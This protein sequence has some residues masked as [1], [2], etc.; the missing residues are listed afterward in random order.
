MLETAGQRESLDQGAAGSASGRTAPTKFRSGRRAT[1]R[2]TPVPAPRDV[3]DASRAKPEPTPALDPAADHVANWGIPLAVVVIG[4]FM[5]VLDVSIVNVAIPAMQKTYGA[6]TDDIEWVATAYNLCLGVVVPASAW[7]GERFGLRRIYIVS[8][9]GF[10]VF[11]GFCGTA[12][13]LGIMIFYRVLQAVPGGLLPV[14]C[15]AILTRIVPPK[16]LGTAMGLYGLGMVVAPGIGPALGGYLVQHLDWRLIFFINVPIGVAGALAAQLVLPRLPGRSSSTFDLPGFACAATGLFAIL[17]AVSEGHQWGWTSYPVLILLAVAA[18]LIVVFVIIERQ[19]PE[20]LLDVRV[21]LRWPFTI[22][23]VLVSLL[24]IGLFAALYY[25]PLFL[26]NGQDITPMNTGLTVLP[27]AA[28]MMLIMPVAGR[29]YDRFGA[30]WPAAIGVLLAGLGLGMMSGFNPDMT[31]GQIVAW[32]VVQASGLA[33]AFIPIM[34]A[35][36]A[37]LPTHLVDSGNAYTNLAQR[38][39]GALGIAIFTAITA[40]WQAQDMADRS[41]LLGH[42]AATN[43]AIQNLRQQ[44]PGGLVPLW[45]ETFVAAQA[46]SYSNAFLC[47]SAVTIL[48]AFLAMLFSHGKPAAGTHV[49]VEIG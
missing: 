6:S 36:L 14:T 11:S 20:P 39:A 48:S 33:I 29:I 16:Q 35:G 45:R 32:T 19:V 27:Q 49:H 30:R 23:I 15:L 18:N 31:R 4:M 3:A 34:T 12:D 1:T 44:G 13:S 25:V 5:S 26:Q 43:P 47:L 9:L 17:L 10:A 22:S 41:G 42:H 2:S 24:S 7:L 21:F 8:I 28:A 38:F 40:A 46:Q 37:S